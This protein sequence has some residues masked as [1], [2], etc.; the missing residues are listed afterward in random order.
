MR[1]L[2]ARSTRRPRSITPADSGYDVP[3]PRPAR[4]ILVLL[5]LVLQ[6]ILAGVRG[7]ALVVDACADARKD[8]AARGALALP[9][10]FE[11]WSRGSHRHDDLPLHVH[12]PED[13]AVRARLQVQ[14][15]EPAQPA[16]PAPPALVSCHNGLSL[17]SAWDTRNPSSAVRLVDRDG[18]SIESLRTIR[19]VV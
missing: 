16:P 12:V 6:V 9:D 4:V 13:G 14:P 5:L 2:R 3:V 10:E 15:G 1:V 8:A 19:I 7:Q 17:R 11:D 18:G